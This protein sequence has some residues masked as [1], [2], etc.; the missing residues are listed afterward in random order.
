MVKRSSMLFYTWVTAITVAAYCLAPIAWAQG[1]AEDVHVAPR[2]QQPQKSGQLAAGADITTDTRP[3]K[4]DVNLV[5]V[6]VS[7]VD[8]MNREVT[9]LDKE[10]FEVFEG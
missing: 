10:N 6:P 3:I 8:P 1:S 9:G 4:V 7:I 2:V 5:L